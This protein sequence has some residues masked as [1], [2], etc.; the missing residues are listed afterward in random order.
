MPSLSARVAGALGLAKK[1][2]SLGTFPA[3]LQT[4]QVAS[5]LPLA[6][7]LCLLLLLHSSINLAPASSLILSCLQIQPPSHPTQD[8]CQTGSCQD[9]EYGGIIPEALGEEH[10]EVVFGRVK[11]P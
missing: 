4:G 10:D 1:G 7:A 3:P 5:I 11:L 8:Y 2:S 9:A 6:F